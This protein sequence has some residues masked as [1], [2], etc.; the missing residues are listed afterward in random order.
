MLLDGEREVRPALDGRIVR[1]EDALLPL[2]DPDPGDDACT[3]R[4]RVVEVPRGEG[5]ELEEGSVR[6]DQPVD[7]LAGSQLAALAVPR[8][9]VLPAACRDSRRTLTELGDELRHPVVS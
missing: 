9:R 4:L 8:K 3:R 1:D 5:V 2:D 6:I 7:P